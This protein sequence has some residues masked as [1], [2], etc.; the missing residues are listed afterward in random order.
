MP[1]PCHDRARPGPGRANLVRRVIGASNRHPPNARTAFANGPGATLSRI[2]AAA[3]P[4]ARPAVREPG[5]D[6]VYGQWPQR[7]YRSLVLKPR[8]WNSY[9]CAEGLYIQAAFRSQSRRPA[10]GSVSRS[11]TPRE[12]AASAS[13]KSSFAPLRRY[14]CMTRSV[15]RTRPARRG[16]V[17]LL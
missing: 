8:A 4:R 10:A 9:Y 14:V 2:R 15:H 17:R 3:A 12:S 11:R 5:T 7:K 16:T 13:A 1:S 6:Y